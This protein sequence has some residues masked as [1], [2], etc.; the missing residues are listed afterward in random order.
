MIAVDTNLLVYAHRSAVPEHA[1]A[2]AAIETAAAHPR[3]WGIAVPTLAEL[4]MVATHPS[5]AGR[6]STP[7]EVRRFVDALCQDAGMVIFTPGR[8]FGQRLCHLATVLGVVGARIFDL[9]IGLMAQEA[10]ASALWT[11]DQRFVAPAG[12]RVHDPLG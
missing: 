1:R 4:W 2:R 7:E 3:G 8:G 6:P 10:G 12:L 11:H 9:Q 5:A